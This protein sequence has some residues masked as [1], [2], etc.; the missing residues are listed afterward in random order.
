MTA[1]TL[2]K[3]NTNP[4]KFPLTQTLPRTHPV[5]RSVSQGVT[6]GQGQNGD[7]GLYNQAGASFVPCRPA[8]SLSSANCLSSSNTKS[9]T[10]TQPCCCCTVSKIYNVLHFPS[11]QENGTIRWRAGGGGGG[12]G[13]GTDELKNAERHQ[14]GVDSA[15]HMKDRTVNRPFTI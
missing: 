1:L 2:V 5:S 14:E 8:V 9:A 10:E 11:W 12:G 4:D 6:D 7:R 13:E 15:V 3:Y